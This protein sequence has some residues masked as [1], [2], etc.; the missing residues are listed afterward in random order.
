MTFATRMTCRTMLLAVSFAIAGCADLAGVREFAS[1][2]ASITGSGELS[3][4]WRD[5][6]QRLAAIPQPGDFP[7]KFSTGDRASVHQETE[8]LLAV[9]TIYMETMGKR[10]LQEVAMQNAQKAAYAKDQIAAIEGFEIAFSSPTFNEFVVRSTKPADEVIEK[11]RTEYDIVGGLALSK[12][13]S[14][15]PNEFLVCVTETN[16]KEQ[17][18]ALVRSLS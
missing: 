8:K 18:D 15:R 7:L 5:T 16:T 10:G 17:I 1:L 4:R 12:Y 11:I 13:Y 6:Q 3:A 9:V 2:S 14:D